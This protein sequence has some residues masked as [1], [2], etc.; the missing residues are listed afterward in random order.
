MRSTSFSVSEAMVYGVSLFFDCVWSGAS[1]SQRNKAR[2]E[3]VVDVDFV[4]LD[5]ILWRK[6][7]KNG[8]AM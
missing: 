3:R 2:S 7:W 4:L 8:V 6:C 5:V 1:L